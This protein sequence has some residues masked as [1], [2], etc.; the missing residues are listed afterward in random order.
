MIRVRDLR[1]WYPLRKGLFGELLGRQPEWVRAVDEISFD[2]RTGEVLCLVG[3]SGCGKTSTGKAIL[4]LADATGGDVFI[5]IPDAEFDRFRAASKKKDEP[6]SAKLVDETRRKYSVSWKEKFRWTRF[7]IMSLATM[8]E[9]AVLLAFVVPAA[10]LGLFSDPFTN[11]WNTLGFAVAVGAIVGAVASLPPARAWRRLP[12]VVAVLSIV[13]VVLGG[14]PTFYFRDLVAPGTGGFGSTALSMAWERDLFGLLIATAFAPIVAAAMS[15]LIVDVRQRTGGLGGMRMRGMRRRLQMIFQ[16]PYESLNPK[17]SV[18]EIVSEPLVVNRITRNPE[19]ITALVQSALRDAGLRPPE[20]FMFRFPHELSGGQRQRVSI[21]AAL[22]LQPDF[23]VADEP[24]S[25][26]DVSIRT[27]I[28]QLMMDL[29]KSRGLTY[30]F[31]THDLSLAWVIADRIAVMYLGKI[32]EL[33]TAEQVIG[34]PKHP[35]TQALISVVPSP[36]PRK[37]VQRMILKGER[38]DPVNIPTGCRFHP[39]CPMAFEPCGWNSEEV[40]AELTALQTDG[41]LPGVAAISV[42]GLH[43]VTMTV[44]P[45]ASAESTVAAVRAAVAAGRNARLGLKGVSRVEAKGGSIEISLNAWFVPELVELA[46][47][48]SVACHLIT[49]PST[50]AAAVTAGAD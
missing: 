19:E 11:S 41:R 44:A 49:P 2:V 45:G 37:R 1:V 7:D 5:E 15:A 32:V 20:E 9:A 29:R 14:I 17:Q 36:D 39:R 21:A 13:L 35:Y 48:N 42:Q 43:N 33:G 4:Q 26:L 38:P 16:D 46:P 18:Y 6:E 8:I 25:M 24:V 3:E 34:Q 27:G 23:I 47:E 22:V 40:V 30:L 31:I 10:I 28:L 50:E 12:I